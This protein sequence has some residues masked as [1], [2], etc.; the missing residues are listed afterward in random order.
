LIAVLIYVIVAWTNLPRLIAIV[1][2][3]YRFP[4]MIED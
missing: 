4:L 1:R 3:R 2:K